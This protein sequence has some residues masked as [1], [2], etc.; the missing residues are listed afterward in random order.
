MRWHEISDDYDDEIVLGT[1]G[2]VTPETS[3]D[4]FNT[5]IRCG[6]ATSQREARD[7]TEE[8]EAVYTVGP[9]HTTWTFVGK[10][11]FDKSILDW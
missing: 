8:A 4:L 3:L 1:P 2:I 10:V 11:G 5:L 9:D 6:A 7:W